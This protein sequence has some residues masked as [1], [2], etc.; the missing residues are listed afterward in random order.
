[1][2]GLI[3]NEL[4]KIVSQKKTLWFIILLLG[5]YLFPVVMTFWARL[6]ALDGQVYAYTMSGLIAGWILP[7]YL[8][9]VI[10]DMVTEER[11]SGTI[12]LPL[13]HPVTRT[14]FVTAKLLALLI[15]MVCLLLLSLVVGYAAGVLFFGWE[16]GFMIRG[17]T[18]HTTWEGIRI[19][20]VSF[21]APVLPLLS[22]ACFVVFLA[23]M[24]S[25]S[26]AV[27]GVAVSYFLL[28]SLAELVL[29]AMKP[30][31]ITSYFISL[32]ELINFNPSYRR[33]I[34][35]LLFIILHG[36]LFYIGTVV[37]FRK[38]DIFS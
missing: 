11:A 22:F 2:R 17:G 31:L 26:A 5:L 14:E 9:V 12:A 16:N 21:L 4:I 15:L 19:T 27:V 20:V 32:S 28:Q 3:K 13:I 18:V 30:Y 24:F 34:V 38:R 10:A 23:F 6:R 1:M 25:G 36:L 37:L 33:L 8:I 29:P 7:V 35:T